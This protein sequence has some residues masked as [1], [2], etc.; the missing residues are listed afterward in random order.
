IDY[1]GHE[2]DAALKSIKNG[3]ATL[4]AGTDYTNA[5]GKV[6]LKDSYLATLKAGNHTLTYNFANGTSSTV[7]V[8]VIE[9]QVVEVKDPVITPEKAVFDKNEPADVV[10]NVT[11]N[12]HE[13]TAIKNGSTVLKAG[14]D[15]S[16]SGN[17][18]T[19]KESYLSTLADGD[20][21][22]AFVFDGNIEKD[23]TVTVKAKDASGD[24]DIDTKLNITADSVKAKAGETVKIPVLINIPD[25][26]D[27]YGVGFDFKID[28]NKAE[29]VKVTK[30]A[31]LEKVA[32][33]VVSNYVP[34]SN[35]VVNYGLFPNA[36]NQTSSLVHGKYTF[37]TFELKLNSDLKSGDVLPID[38]VNMTYATKDGKAMNLTS[39]IGDI[40]IL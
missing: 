26:V 39:K 34:A 15:Y 29:F 22:I 5:N 9:K 25:D 20:A 28:S 10:V 37:A 16:V 3:N 35:T 13:L 7:T 33:V 23:L 38:I 21:K 12:N 40:V 6:T 1:K 19:I 24:E 36:K 4:K 8:K 31:E 17:K 27:T 30:G 11:Y 14:K 32:D 18:V 2:K